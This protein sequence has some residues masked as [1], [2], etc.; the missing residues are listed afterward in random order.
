MQCVPLKTD[1]PFE[2]Q[3]L[4]R[5]RRRF[6]VERTAVIN[7][8]R[9]LLLEHGIVVPVGREL[10]ARRLPAIFEDAE[11]GLSPRVVARLHRLRQRWLAID[12]EIDQ[13]TRALI[14]WAKES[15]LC[16]RVVT[17]PGVGPLIA[18]ALVAAVGDARRLQRPDKLPLATGLT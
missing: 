18:T 14:A 9:A 2:L 13:A 15:D 8:I 17:V 10:F 12:S 4:H 7:Q 1:P 16:R 6:I 5:V 3:A 11:N